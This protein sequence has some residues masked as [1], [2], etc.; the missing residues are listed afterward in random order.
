MIA[1]MVSKWTGD[2]LTEGGIYEGHIR[3]NDYPYL[4]GYEELEHTMVAADVM[5]PR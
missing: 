1:A 5:Q 4:G 3:L 2:R